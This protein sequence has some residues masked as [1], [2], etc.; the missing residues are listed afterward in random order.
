MEPTV[1]EQQ[2]MQRLEADLW[3]ILV[4][5][6]VPYCIIK[7]FVGLEYTS[8]QEFVDIYRDKDA[9]KDDAPHGNDQVKTFTTIPVRSNMDPLWANDH[10][11][12]KLRCGNTAVI[13]SSV[14]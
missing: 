7:N 5:S 13:P 8:F 3:L 4:N 12:V 9:L 14:F 6:K 11:Q 10:S 1:D 2:A